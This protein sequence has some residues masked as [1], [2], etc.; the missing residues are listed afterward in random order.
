M[1]NTVKSLVSRLNCYRD[2]YYNRAESLIYDSEYDKLFDQLKQLEQQTGIV[3]SNSPTK[4]VGYEVKSKLKKVNHDIPLLS[5]DKTKST[6]TLLE[7]A[8][9]NPCLLMLKLDGL[10]VELLY[11]SGELVQASTRGDGHVG[12]DI[13]HNAKAFKN[14]PLAIPYKGLLRVTGEAIIHRRDFEAINNN[15]PANETSYANVRNLA[16]GSVRQLDSKICANRNVH[17][18]LWDVL[19]G[20]DE[21]CSNTRS[22]KIAYC[23]SMG[24]ES[25]A[26]KYFVYDND[27]ERL[28]Q[29]IEELKVIAA[30]ES[31]PI[32][33]LVMKYDSITYSKQQG[34]T[35]H[36][37]NDG[38]AFKFEDESAET[39]LQD[40][41]WSLGRTGQL[42][43]VAIF[44]PVE[45]DGTT[46]IRAS[47]HNITVMK[48]IL[49][50]Y[51]YRC[52]KISVIK[53]NQIIPQIV[54]SEKQC[55]PES[56]SPVALES[57]KIPDHCPVCG[58]PTAIEK[59]NNTE[60]LLCVNPHC[61]GKILSKFEHFVSKSAMNIEGI[62]T[63]TL[64]QFIEMGW[65]N[66][67]AD[68]Y[69]LDQH[70]SEIIRMDGFG[71]RAYDKIWDSIQKSTTV[72]LDKL[73][74]GLSIPAVGKSAAKTISDYC[75]GDIS[76]FESLII[77][78]FNWELL[79]DFGQ[80]TSN[81]INSWF[82]DEINANF[83]VNLM[84]W[85]QINKPNK[86]PETT[87]MSYLQ[88]L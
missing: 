2:A 54:C 59:L 25:C 47:L 4:T 55:P 13:T 65:L 6:D 52:Q 8:R 51:P 14:I 36:H 45:L 75:D 22:D 71:E 67:Y 19:E 83:Y 66:E 12:E 31:I 50:E 63:A 35:S 53:A 70:R 15:L 86:R 33:G 48:N 44:D 77:Q 38:L 41:E 30:A 28:P 80:V 21:E 43:P 60:T 3:L 79:N 5:L 9:P 39:K 16:S 57:L 1:I 24:F 85:I 17:F 7:F 58:C 34:G 81:N 62:S 69:K 82:K 49:G 87:T 72:S 40:I 10:T 78:G 23:I 32:D 56:K 88:I 37:N 27:K 29:W 73:I 11:K 18:I 61:K 84:N 76:K 64:K 68:I 42:T 46:V 74:T 20:L 26:T